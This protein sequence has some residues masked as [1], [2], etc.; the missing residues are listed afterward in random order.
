M[1]YKMVNEGKFARFCAILVLIGLIAALFVINSRVDKLI[2]LERSGINLV[3]SLADNQAQ[4]TNHLG[5]ILERLESAEESNNMLSN[6]IQ[7]VDKRVRAIEE[8]KSAPI[9]L[10]RSEGGQAQAA[11]VFESEVTAY[12]AD[13]HCTGK[14]DGIT[15]SGMKAVEGITVAADLKKY[16]LGTKLKIE[17]YDN[18]FEV[19]DK[20]GAIS[21]NDIDIFFN[22]HDAAN[23][24]GRQILK[25]EI[26]G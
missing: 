18:V 22:S 9:S 15:F 23:N 5:D 10:I 3:Q 21:N 13:V 4:I 14:T 16:P 2:E 8:K 12:T 20:G 25:V 1:K 11:M 7:E 19:Q 6:Q 26:V 17:G 24:F